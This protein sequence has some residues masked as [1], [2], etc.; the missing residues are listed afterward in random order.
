MPDKDTNLFGEVGDADIGEVS[1]RTVSPAGEQATDQKGQTSDENVPFHQ[2]PRW[3]EVYEKAQRVENLER[4]LANLKTQV[5]QKPQG[6]EWQPKTWQEVI[7]KAKEETFSQ[8][9]QYQE[10]EQTRI[11][12]EDKALADALV[13]LKDQVGEFDEQKLLQFCYSHR[14]G[15]IFVGYELMKKIEGAEKTGEKHALRKK[16]APIG[17]SAKT[18]GGVKQ[19]TPYQSLR[20]KSLDDIVSEAVER[21]S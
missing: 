12:A 7:Q 5:G 3:K 2:H 6:E 21:I 10:A 14:I 15:D 19:T 18:E 20:N 1:D 17:S 4:E 16:V 11:T 8:L 13:Q 9:Q